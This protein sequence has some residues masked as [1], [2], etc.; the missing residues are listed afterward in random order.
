MG[1]DDAGSRGTAFVPASPR[2]EERVRDSFSR[3]QFMQTLGVRIVRIAVGEVELEVDHH[4]GLTQQHGYLHAGVTSALADT[5][6]G[7]AAYTLAGDDQ[8]VLT[9]EY[10][11]NLVAPGMGDRFRA[12]GTVVAAGRRLK[13]VVATV[14]G[15]SAGSSRLVAQVQATLMTPTGS[16]TS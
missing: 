4:A 14:H 5:A 11:I 1:A 7:Y 2:W 10:K 15:E 16:D 8:T 9:V 12:V 13:T 6:C 3:Q